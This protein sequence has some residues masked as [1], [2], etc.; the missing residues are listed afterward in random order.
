MD[1]TSTRI[2]KDKS[3]PIVNPRSKKYTEVPP[4]SKAKSEYKV[5][6]I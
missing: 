4:K 6:D 5:S 3:A 1:S 2:I